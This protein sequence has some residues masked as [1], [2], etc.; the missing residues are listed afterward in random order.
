MP[1]SI[2]QPVRSA[3]TTPRFVISMNSRSSSFPGGWYM[4]S[5]MMT[6]IYGAAS[7]RDGLAAS[8][9]HADTKMHC[10]RR[11]IENPCMNASLYVY[12]TLPVPQPDFS[13]SLYCKHRRGMELG[14]FPSI[15]CNACGL[16]SSPLSNRPWGPD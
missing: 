13:A 6:S 4:I 15:L 5:L 16:D 12:Q 11:W 2:R 7:E 9:A 3:L 8:R 10:H 1:S 14:G